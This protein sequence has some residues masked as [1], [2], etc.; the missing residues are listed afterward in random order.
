MK[1]EKPYR[2]LTKLRLR[3]GLT[4]EQLA[5]RM[6]IMAAH[7]IS[8]WENG[9]DTPVA[10][11][12][13]A[14]AAALEV[15]TDEVIAALENKPILREQPP[16]PPLLEDRGFYGVFTRLGNGAE[17]FCVA[18]FDQQDEALKYNRLHVVDGFVREVYVKVYSAYPREETA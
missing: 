8:L 18:L 1:T 6:G 14:L 3:L 15:T 7:T 5:E 17:G 10:T 13:P 16:E 12:I 9:H 11:R 2:E 4:Q